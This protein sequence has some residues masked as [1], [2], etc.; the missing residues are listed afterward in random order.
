MLHIVIGFLKETQAAGCL[1]Q[2]E[3]ADPCK[4]KE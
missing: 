2:Q 1:K 4:I 3:Q